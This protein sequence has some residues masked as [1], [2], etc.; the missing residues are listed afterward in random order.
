MFN[1]R[2]T[3][4]FFCVDADRSSGKILDGGLRYYLDNITY[5]HKATGNDTSSKD[6]QK[7]VAR[8][9]NYYGQ[10]IRLG[11]G[12]DNTLDP[13][14]YDKPMKEIGGNTSQGKHLKTKHIQKYYSG[15]DTINYGQNQQDIQGT[16]YERNNAVIQ[17]QHNYE[18]RDS[19]NNFV[20]LNK[21][22]FYESSESVTARSHYTNNLPFLKE[23]NL[24]SSQQLGGNTLQQFQDTN[25]NMNTPVFP[26]NV[27]PK[28]HRDFSNID[29]LEKVSDSI[30]TTLNQPNTFQTKQNADTTYGYVKDHHGN[31]YVEV[32]LISAIIRSKLSA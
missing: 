27:K 22:P 19:Q 26:N 31:S 11:N 25:G 14:H 10:K 15:Y 24:L 16:T 28:V 30:T 3:L 32:I 4:R 13:K 9:E 18:Y 21:V 1:T 20:K 29:T 2:G 8:T 7:Y 6:G 23:E 17:N 5:S 12:R